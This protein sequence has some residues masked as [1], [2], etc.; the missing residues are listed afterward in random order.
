MDDNDLQKLFTAELNKLA[1]TV[2]TMIQW[3]SPTTGRSELKT[4][5]NDSMHCNDSYIIDTGIHHSSS[6]R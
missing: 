2:V 4:M 5:A 3:Y 1:S 6:T